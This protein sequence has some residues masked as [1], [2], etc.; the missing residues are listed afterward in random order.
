MQRTFSILFPS[1]FRWWCRAVLEVCRLLS[2]CYRY[3]AGARRSKTRASNIYPLLMPSYVWKGIVQITQKT[4]PWTTTWDSSRAGDKTDRQ[5]DKQQQQQ[6]HRQQQ[7][8]RDRKEVQPGQGREDKPNSS[9]AVC[10]YRGARGG[11]PGYGVVELK[12][13]PAVVVSASSGEA[14]GTRRRLTS[15]AGR[16]G[17]GFG[18]EVR[19]RGRGGRGRGRGRGMG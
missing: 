18:V 10:K 19:G 12:P 4:K 3:I 13:S 17:F 5:T 1:L 15:V 16:F 2:R 11:V 8:Q 14:T 7:Q 9:N 6:Q